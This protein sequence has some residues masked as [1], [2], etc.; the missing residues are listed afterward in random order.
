MKNKLIIGTALLI[1]GLVLGFLPQYRQLAAA[2]QETEVLRQQLAVSKRSDTL[3][4]FRN[5]AALL[6]VETTRSNFTVALDLGSRY[7]TDLQAFSSQTADSAL[8]QELSEILLSRDAIIAG[9]AKPDPA[10]AQQIQEL[11]LKL[12]KID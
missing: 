2:R 9:L 8:K 4:A 6:Y 12:Q 10:V 11:F 5:R 7:F 1:V 3:N